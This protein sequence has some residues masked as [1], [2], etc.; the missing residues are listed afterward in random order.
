[1][2]PSTIPLLNLD[3]AAAAGHAAGRG[4]SA[5]ARSG[6]AIGE[7]LVNNRVEMLKLRETDGTA[8]AA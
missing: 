3:P 4:C 5:P 2:R 7:E 8:P 1:M 6:S